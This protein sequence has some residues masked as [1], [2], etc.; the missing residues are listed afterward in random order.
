MSS[1]A[2]EFV[3]QLLVLDPDKRIDAESALGLAWLNLEGKTS[4]SLREK[5]EE[6]ARDSILRYASYPKLKK[7]VNKCQGIFVN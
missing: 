3:Q 5:E 2:K 6:L 4:T 1:K 7:M